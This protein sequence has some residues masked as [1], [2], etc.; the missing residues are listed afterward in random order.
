MRATMMKAAAWCALHLAIWGGTAGAD[1]SLTISYRDGST[2]AV[3][4]KEPSSQILGITFSGGA[5]VQRGLIT[6]VAASYGF[7]CG[8]AY[9]NVTDDLAR[10]CNG[11][12]SCAYTVDNRILGDPAVGCAKD[13]RAEWRCGGSAEIQRTIVPPEAGLNSKAFL[14]CD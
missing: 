9:G 14:A 11:R 5:S 2:Q 4:L 3:K 13:Y 6:V 12:T 7:N 8:A 1:D 10:A